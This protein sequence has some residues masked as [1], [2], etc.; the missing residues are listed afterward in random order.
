VEGNPVL[1]MAE[2]F[3]FT[4]YNSMIIERSSKFGGNLELKQAELLDLYGK[5]E[6]HPLDLKNAVSKYLIQIFEPVRD[7]LN[8]H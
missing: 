5:G 8:N 1:E 7:Y 4:K 3:I 2:H 6:L